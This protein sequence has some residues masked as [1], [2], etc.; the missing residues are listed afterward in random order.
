MAQNYES[1]KIVMDRLLRNNALSGISFESV[2]DY[3]IDFFDIVGVPSIYE[4]RYFEAKIEN[5]RVKLPC[6]F[7]EDIQIL[8]APKGSNH[9]IPARSATDTFHNNYDCANVNTSKD[10]TVSLNNNFIF[11]SLE[12]GKL[13]MTY[14]AIVTDEEGYP[15]L[16]SDRT[17]ILALEAYIKKEYFQ[18][19]WDEGKIEDK[20]YEVAQNEY[21]WAVGRC[22][23][24]MQRLSLSEAESFFNSFRTLVPRD[25]E[26]SK[27]FSH[28]GSKEFIKNH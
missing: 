12:T 25:N 19:L 6:D 7:I 3:T 9:F 11:T 5:Y 27:R 13:K 4:E 18:I 23:T 14:R 28:L 21:V 22:E 10:F 8:L 26:F 24:H 16:P 15:M 2:I 17:F 20:R 1:L